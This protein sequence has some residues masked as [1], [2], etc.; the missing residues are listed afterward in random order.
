MLININIMKKI[1]LIFGL[2]VISLFAVKSTFG[3]SVI[4]T[5]YPPGQEPVTAEDMGIEEPSV[6]PDSPFYFLKKWGESIDLAFT[7][8]RA[9]KAEKTMGYA[10]ERLIEARTLLQERANEVSANA[11][12]K[13]DYDLLKTIQDYKNKVNVAVSHAYWA[14]KN[15]SKVDYLLESFDYQQFEQVKLLNQVDDVEIYNIHEELYK[16]ILLA[17]NEVIGMYNDE[18]AQ[19]ENIEER[20]TKL[21]E[22]LAEGVMDKSAIAETENLVVIK[23]LLY[24]LNPK[25]SEKVDQV[26]KTMMDSL[27]NKLEVLEDA[28]KNTFFNNLNQ[29]KASKVAMI[30]ML[31]SLDYNNIPHLKSRAIWD[32]KENKITQIEEQFKDVADKR[33]KEE[34]FK[35][36]AE[37]N[38][39]NLRILQDLNN[40]TPN[41]FEFNQWRRQAMGKI[42]RE[43][44]EIDTPQER[45]A[46]L[47]KDGRIP[48]V[49]DFELLEQMQ[50]EAGEE[51][52]LYNGIVTNAFDILDKSLN[53]IASNDS[54]QAFIDEIAGEDP[55]Q[56]QA[57]YDLIPKLPQSAQANVNKIL[58]K[59]MLRV[60]DRIENK[61]NFNEILELRKRLDGNETVKNIVLEKNPNII[62]NLNDHQ[63]QASFASIDKEEDPIKVF[64][65]VESYKTGLD[66]YPEI[67]ESLELFNPGYIEEYNLKQINKIESII[68]TTTDVNT[69]T[70]FANR[71]AEYKGSNMVNQEIVNRIEIMIQ[72]KQRTNLVEEILTNFPEHELL[73]GSLDG[74][75]STLISE[76]QDFEFTGD[77]DKDQATLK[78]L[79]TEE[80][81]IVKKQREEELMEYINSGQEIPAELDPAQY[82]ALRQKAL[83]K[84]TGDDI[85]TS[86]PMTE[87]EQQQVADDAAQKAAE[88][89]AQ[90]AEEEAAAAAAQEAEQK[91][92]EEAGAP[93]ATGG[94]GSTSGSNNQGT[95]SGTPPA[96]SI[97][98]SSYNWP[99]DCSYITD[100]S[101]RSICEQCQ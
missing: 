95:S 94:T 35:P 92:R 41:L 51:K 34:V 65:L 100:A 77:Y 52:W 47:F 7:F 57:V 39:E 66:E 26:N 86:T 55:E 81:E 56:I 88:E 29:L 11:R 24:G 23:D 71:L 76:V 89:A 82:E 98:C 58:D 17:K 3:Q 91:A 84:Y 37:G 22:K 63:I 74:L 83:E 36:L 62:K 101:Q 64:E 53:G 97:D 96:G 72:N 30:K 99:P 42:W 44:R 12:G 28:D 14:D 43:L 79:I 33:L 48:D 93:N 32:L 50:A 27:S 38:L 10:S 49:K 73:G 15:F 19:S 2:L 85:D 68:S 9:K 31:D 45:Q 40:N 80:I 60:E 78:A 70:D 21:N 20:L 59:Q 75:K 69:L 67:R 1:C 6:M 25:V 46:F 54:R 8:D 13:A 5:N 4:A 61:E 87:E 90:K 16:E 18:L